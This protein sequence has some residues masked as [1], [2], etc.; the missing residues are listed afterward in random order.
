M[1]AKFYGDYQFL[2]ELVSD[3]WIEQLDEIVSHLK[4]HANGHPRNHMVEF[5][6]LVEDDDYSASI[7]GYYIY[8][9]D[10]ARVLRSLCQTF[11]AG[12]QHHSRHYAVYTN[13]TRQMVAFVGHDETFVFV[14]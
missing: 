11:V 12:S 5:V 7:C 1:I 4:L 14:N 8:A 13:D 10:E 6:D 2:F 9:G 3:H